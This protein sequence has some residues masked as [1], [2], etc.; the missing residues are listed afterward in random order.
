[1]IAQPTEP[2]ARSAPRIASATQAVVGTSLMGMNET[3]RNSGDT[4][5]AV[6][7]AIASG[8]PTPSSWRIRNVNSTVATDA[9]TATASGPH[10]HPSNSAPA[11]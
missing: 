8:R 9:S 4:A 3:K 10:C 6:A 5:I 11:A 7:P 1:M 2:R